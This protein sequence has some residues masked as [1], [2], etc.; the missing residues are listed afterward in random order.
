MMRVPAISSIDVAS[1]PCQCLHCAQ[2]QLQMMAQHTPQRDGGCEA[3]LSFGTP[4]DQYASIL[5]NSPQSVA[6]P[7]MVDDSM[8]MTKTPPHRQ[9][10][11]F[12]ST[13][14]RGGD[15]NSNYRP[16]FGQDSSSARRDGA[17]N[18]NNS[19]SLSSSNR[20]NHN[21]NNRSS[22]AV[23]DKFTNSN[24]AVLGSTRRVPL[25]S[26]GPL[27]ANTTSSMLSSTPSSNSK[28]SSASSPAV[29]GATYKTTLE[30]H[31]GRRVTVASHMPLAPGQHVVF[32]GDR[33]DDLGKVMAIETTKVN[34]SLPL[35]IRP[36]T[37]D[38]VTKW[39]TALVDEA[40]AS[41]AVCNHTVQ[42][43]GLPLTVVHASFQFDRKKL[44]FFYDSDE[45]VD[46]RRLLT[47]MYNKFRCRIWMERTEVLSQSPDQ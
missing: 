18:N 33:G 31:L 17:H 4:E 45:R 38:E 42:Q 10:M 3:P 8:M 2:A 27:R 12:G 9:P 39:S 46:F 29:A 24:N 20:R 15:T 36:A 40:E 19:S 32:E 43:M 5:S 7:L 6:R 26:Q 41:V 44:T 1:E 37:A 35:V 16:R 25:G 47:E 14:R 11:M 13:N 28:H 34:S 22:P 23:D 30:G 21:N